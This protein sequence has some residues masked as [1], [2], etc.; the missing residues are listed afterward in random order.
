MKTL[1]WLLLGIFLIAGVSSCKVSKKK[2]QK[3]IVGFYQELKDSFPNAEVTLLKDSIKV[4]FPDN[5][6]FD[7]GSAIW[8]D[9]FFE[10]LARFSVLVNKYDKTNL[11]ITGHTDNTGEGEINDKLSKTRADN[12][13]LKMQE[14]KVLPARLFV[15]G[16]GARQPR[17]T[18]STEEGRARNRRVEFVVLYKED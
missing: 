2:K 3:Y 12:V 18:N 7:V 16:L 14:Y 11:L 1:T 13:K 8:K 9:A 17:D 4:I 6:M 15:W 10:K 5:I